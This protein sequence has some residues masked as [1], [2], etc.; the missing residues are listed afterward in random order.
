MF[1]SEFVEIMGLITLA[2]MAMVLV[3]KYDSKTRKYEIKQ[4]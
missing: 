4:A 3:Y 2:G 1:D